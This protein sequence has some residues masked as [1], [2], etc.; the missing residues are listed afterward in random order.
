MRSINI[1]ALLPLLT[2]AALSASPP[3][4]RKEPNIAQYYNSPNEAFQDL[5]NALPEES[6]HAALVSSLSHFRDGVFESDRHGVEAIHQENPPLAT[7]LIVEAVRDLKKKRQANNTN[8][9][10][11]AEAGATTTTT[12]PTS[13]TPA[14]LVPVQIPTTDAKGNPTTTTLDV[15]S[16]ATVSIPQT[17]TTT[18][19]AGHTA[20]ITTTKPAIIHTTTNSAGAPITTTS[21]VDYAPSIGQVLSTTNAAGSA[22]VTTYTPDGGKVSSIVLQTTTGQDGQPTVVTS[23]TY[24]EPAM[25]TG[26]KTEAAATTAK[27]GLQS[28][29]AVPVARVGHAVRLVGGVGGL[30]VAMFV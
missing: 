15:L 13:T 27:P 14:V 18:N 29:A 10:T 26:S 3:T 19:S 1:L 20:T 4:P 16:A 25:A 7:K 12:P 17:L 2:P 5:L 8:G 23:Y 28:A 9:T 11:A 21:A 22:F 30:V 24:V 6:L